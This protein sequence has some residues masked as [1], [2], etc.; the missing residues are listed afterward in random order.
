MEVARRA[1][2]HACKKASN[3]VTHVARYVGVTRLIECL[4]ESLCDLLDLAP[5]GLSGATGAGI[6]SGGVST[7]GFSTVPSLIVS[8]A[9]YELS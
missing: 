9:I 8:T 3:T 4:T 7:S 5:D 1:T 2:T 6:P